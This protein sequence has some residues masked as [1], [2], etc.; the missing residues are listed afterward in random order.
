MLAVPTDPP[1]ST[2]TR[3][4]GAL[5]IERAVCA[6][7]ARPQYLARIYSWGWQQVYNCINMSKT[8]A[9]EGCILID[10]AES[11]EAATFGVVNVAAGVVAC[12][13]LATCLDGDG[14]PKC[15]DPLAIDAACHYL[16]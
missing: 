13:Q 16:A 15:F 7:A 14:L 9:P 2:D 6:C 8:C 10:I 5:A 11:R 4:T 1:W 3:T 12:T